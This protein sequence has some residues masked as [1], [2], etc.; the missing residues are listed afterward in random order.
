MIRY[1]TEVRFYKTEVEYVF[2]WGFR[3]KQMGTACEQTFTYYS[4][5]GVRVRDAGLHCNFSPQ[6]GEGEGV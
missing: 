5:F 3:G 6:E 4:R 1:K 2:S